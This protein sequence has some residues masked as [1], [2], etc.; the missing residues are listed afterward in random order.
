MLIRGA[1]LHSQLTLC[2]QRDTNISPATDVCHTLQNTAAKKRVHCTLRGPF[3][4]LFPA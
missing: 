3:D 2:S 1:T 4:N